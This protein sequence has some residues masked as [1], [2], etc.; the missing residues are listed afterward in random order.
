MY[1]SFNVV[2]KRNDNYVLKEQKA[3]Q[4]KANL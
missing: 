4:E 2:S 3:A 1:V